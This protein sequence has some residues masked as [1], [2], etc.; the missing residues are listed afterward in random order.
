MTAEHPS[1]PYSVSMEIL[2]A[3]SRV[4]PEKQVAAQVHDQSAEGPGAWDERTRQ[5]RLAGGA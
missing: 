3:Q 5:A 4:L 1:N 2:E